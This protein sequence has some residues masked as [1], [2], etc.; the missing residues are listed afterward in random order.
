[1]ESVA[2]VMLA[3]RSVMPVVISA[4]PAV[5]RV[6]LVACQDAAALAPRRLAVAAVPALVLL[7]ALLAV[8]HALLVADA[9]LVTPLSRPV[10]LRY[11]LRRLVVLAD[12][13]LSP[14]AV[15]DAH[16]RL[17]LLVQRPAVLA[18]LAAQRLVALA[19]LAALSPAALVLMDPVRRLAAVAMTNAASAIAAPPA[20]A[21]E[22]AASAV[23]LLVNTLQHFNTTN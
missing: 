8:E 4:M 3:A 12:V 16:L 14:L 9:L 2:A 22:S 13:V 6:T 17:A 19:L 11:A 15:S 20:V 1:M 5:R 23:I 18:L 10:H 7:L 21:E